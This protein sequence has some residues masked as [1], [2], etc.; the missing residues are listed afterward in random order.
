M[1]SVVSI[2][3]QLL[4]TLVALIG[5]WFA[6]VVCIV[7]IAF[8]GIGGDQRGSVGLSDGR[9]VHVVLSYSRLDCCIDPTLL[10]NSTNITAL[11]TLYL[12]QSRCACGSAMCRTV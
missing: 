9:G 4:G 11:A 7:V 8:T 1:V 5:G 2:F 3:K 6:G 12:H 10:G